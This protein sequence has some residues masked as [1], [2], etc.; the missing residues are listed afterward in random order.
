MASTASHFGTPSLVARLGVYAFPRVNGATSGSFWRTTVYG[1]T[2]TDGR[3]LLVQGCLIVKSQLR[4]CSDDI[5]QPGNSE[6]AGRLCCHDSR[7][8]GS[9]PVRQTNGHR[10]QHSPDV[11]HDRA[12]HHHEATRQNA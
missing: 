9:C 2:A 4:R 7:R 6:P 3:I 5:I 8:L 1:D 12:N 11:G 10:A